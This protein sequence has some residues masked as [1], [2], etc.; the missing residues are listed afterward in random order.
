MAALVLEQNEPFRA[1]RD[2]H[3]HGHLA[4]RKWDS[5]GLKPNV[6]STS[7][8][9]LCFILLFFF[10][11]GVENLKNGVLRRPSLHVFLYTGFPEEAEVHM[12]LD[13]RNGNAWAEHPGGEKPTLQLLPK[14]YILWTKSCIT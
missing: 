8:W 12:T 2:S 11:L 3:P 13:L 5:F 6:S 1:S 4:T 7:S 10:G 14:G 9:V